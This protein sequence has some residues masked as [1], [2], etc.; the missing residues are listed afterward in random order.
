MARIWI[1]LAL[2][3]GACATGERGTFLPP[4]SRS[5]I[6][7]EKFVRIGGIEQWVSIRGADTRN[8]VIVVVHGGPAVANSS[9][10]GPYRAWE[11]NFTV[12]QWDQRG[13]GKTFGRNGKSTPDV[14]AERIA[15]DGIEVAQYSRH[16]LDK[17]K[18]ILLGHS[19]GSLLGVTMI[20]KRPDLFSAYVGTG[21][22]VSFA[23]AT[24]AQY[25]DL[26]RRAGAEGNQDALLKLHDIGPPPYEMGPKFFELQAWNDRYLPRADADYLHTMVDMVRA[27]PKST[28]Q[29]T[30]SWIDG[31]QFSMRLLSGAVLAADLPAAEGYEMPVPFFIIQGSE[32]RITPTAL[33]ED[34]FQHIQAP[35]KAMALISGAGHFA[36]A[37]HGEAFLAALEKFVARDSLP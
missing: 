9:L 20:R 2:V 5:A 10:P 36:Y 35:R 28:P 22:V 13:A 17:Q 31:R 34:Y 14:T 18:V 6:A 7:E 1:A 3:L 8:P 25:G 27:A 21:Q 23:R 11:G 29:E 12:V 26:V 16:R 4:G 15:E 30:Q 32:D 19:W 37:T 33:V 24:K